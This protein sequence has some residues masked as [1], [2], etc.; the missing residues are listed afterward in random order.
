MR[1]IA[2]CHFYLDTFIARRSAI[3]SGA[4]KIN[5]TMQVVRELAR[6]KTESHRSLTFS[7]TAV[8]KLA[9]DSRK[10][11]IESNAII[12]SSNDK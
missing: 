7:M 4:E 11:M 6:D 1:E 3:V 8:V 10:R 12:A 9:M 5:F 2:P